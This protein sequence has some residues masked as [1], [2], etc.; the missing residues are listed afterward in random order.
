MT[1]IAPATAALFA[2]A[3]LK[4]LQDDPALRMLDRLETRI[5][6]CHAL[7]LSRVDLITKSE[8]R[9]TNDEAQHLAA[10][11]ARRQQGEPIAYIV[12]QREFYGLPFKVTPDVLIPRPETEMLVDLALERLHKAGSDAGTG[13]GRV[14][15]LGTGSGAIAVAIAHARPHATVCALDNS[16]AALRIA[17]HNADLNL[18]GSGTTVHFLLSDWY[19]ALHQQPANNGDNGGNSDD[20]SAFLTPFDVIVANP[21]YIVAFDHHLSEGDLRFEPINALTDHADGLSALRRIIDGA[22]AHLASGGW[23]LIEHGYDQAS[24]AQAWL[25]AH[26][27]SQVQ[28]WPDL[29]GIPRVSG[30]KRYF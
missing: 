24:A 23:L 6:L 12:G 3:T 11:F 18:Q 4:C 21:P 8:R 17:A 25:A 15:D 20:F 22:P 10:L 2:D 19:A 7:S 27:F 30:G 26:G 16:A 14:L 29:A 9:I 5:L 13:A 28:S 1:A